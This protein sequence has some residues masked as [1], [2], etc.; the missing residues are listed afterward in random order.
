MNFESG[1]LMG[2]LRLLEEIGEGGSSTVWS[3]RHLR[4]GHDVAVKFL[5]GPASLLQPGT[6]GV[7]HREVLVASALESPYLV[8]FFEEGTTDDG[9]TYYVME[10]LNGIDLG[11][12]VMATGPLTLRETRRLVEQLASVLEQAHALG[13]VHRDIKPDNVFVLDGAELTVKLLDFGIAKFGDSIGSRTSRASRPSTMTRGGVVVGSPDF[14]SPEQSIS[15][16][17]VDHR[18]DLFALGVLAYFALTAELPFAGAEKAARWKLIENGP[19]SV[20][21]WSGGAPATLDDW[22]RRALALLPQDRFQSARQMSES[23]GTLLGENSLSD[24]TARASR[25]NSRE[26]DDA[27]AAPLCSSDRQEHVAAHLSPRVAPLD[28]SAASAADFTDPRRS[29]AETAA[30][31]REAALSSRDPATAAQASRVGASAISI[32]DELVPSPLWCALLAVTVGAASLI[33]L[34]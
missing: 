4:L 9:T 7:G 10:L 27:A 33:W 2:D 6:M 20:R 16:R 23:L 31:P 29:S 1:A 17:D 19:I 18:S 15:S 32:H 12:A 21:R 5:H 28:S 14:V 3:A 22:F 25:F 34:M 11:R 26:T 8:K 30:V 13:I 24:P